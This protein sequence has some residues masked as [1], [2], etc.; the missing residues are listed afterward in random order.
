[1]NTSQKYSGLAGRLGLSRRLCV[2]YGLT[3]LLACEV[4]PIW[5][6]WAFSSTFSW[7]NLGL[8]LLGM[9]ILG[10]Q[11]GIILLPVFLVGWV[12]VW[13]FCRWLGLGMRAG[14]ACAA[15]CGSLLP[16]LIFNLAEGRTAGNEWLW[17]RI[18]DPLTVIVPLI[19][20]LLALVLFRRP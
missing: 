11:A 19:A 2:L 15:L 4:Y 13:L 8:G 16:F 12:L 14:A 5:F 18:I 7:R 1:M 17:A 6:M 9:P 20:T 3:A 10:F